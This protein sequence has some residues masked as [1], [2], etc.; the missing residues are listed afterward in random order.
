MSVREQYVLVLL[1]TISTSPP[2]VD[3]DK[4]YDEIK[5]LIQIAESRGV[6][7]VCVSGY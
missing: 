4:L 3:R 7:A 1:G 6:S 2:I 5:T